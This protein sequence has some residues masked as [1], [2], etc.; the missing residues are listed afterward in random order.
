MVQASPAWQ[1]AMRWCWGTQ[2]YYA[3]IID[4]TTKF[5]WDPHWYATVT[6]NYFEQKDYVDQQWSD[7]ITKF[8]QG[9]YFDAGMF[10][11]R[12]LLALGKP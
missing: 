12:P 5:F 1:Q 10:Y 6:K 4:Q 9:V 3:E 11:G 2:H 8:Q 7:G